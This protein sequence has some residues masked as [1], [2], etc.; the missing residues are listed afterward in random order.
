MML[1][2]AGITQ[3]CALILSIIRA[4]VS[5]SLTSYVPIFHSILHPPTRLLTTHT[6]ALPTGREFSL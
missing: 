6:Q 5:H 3:A 1:L 2:L 4:A